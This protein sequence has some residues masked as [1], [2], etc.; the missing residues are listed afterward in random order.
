MA[1]AKIDPFDVEALEKSLNDSATRVSA[2]WISF[3]IFALYL[4]TAATTVTHR[5][6]LLDEPVKLPVL[7]IDLPLWGFF[8]LAPI[9]FL[10]FHIYVLLQVLLL[11]RTAVVYN[12]AVNEKVKA[13]AD[14]SRIRQRLANT[15]F[16][17]IFAGSPR[18][19]EGWLGWLL[20]AMAWI[21]LVV[22]P[23]SIL[24]AFQFAFLPYHS[25]F[26]TWTHRLLLLIELAIS[27]LLWPLVL[28]AGDNLNWPRMKRRLKRSMTF[29]APLLLSLLCRQTSNFP[30]PKRRTC[31]VFWRRAR[32]AFPIT[33]FL[34][35][36][37]F[38]L[39]LATY[40]GEWHV[41]LITGQSWSAV[42]CDRWFTNSFD[43]LH[44]PGIDIVDDKKLS[45][46]VEATSK[47][48]LPG[49]AGERTR[50]LRGRNLNC[51]DLS[52]A[53]LRRADFSAAHLSGADLTRSALEG[54]SFVR[55]ELR[56]AILF[57]AKLQGASLAEAQ[58]QGASL[59]S[60]ELAGAT[61]DR[62]SLQGATLTSAQLQG[63]LLAYASLQGANLIS[64]DLQG[65]SLFQARLQGASLE[66]AI[67][68]GATLDGARLQG[69][70]LNSA[71][72]QGASLAGAWLQGADLSNAKFLW[73]DMS[74]AYIWRAV[75]TACTGQP[76]GG[77]PETIL[78]AERDRTISTARNE[79]LSYIEDITSD[80][81]TRPARDLIHFHA[82]NREYA[83]NHLKRRLITDDVAAIALGRSE[84]NAVAKSEAEF[85]TG[86][87]LFLRN[88]VC[89]APAN[90]RALINSI[91]RDRLFKFGPA[92][93][94]SS[95]PFVARVF[96]GR[97]DGKPCA[98]TADLSDALKGSLRQIVDNAPPTV[99]SAAPPDDG[100]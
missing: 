16:A 17:Q 76:V 6:F 78:D 60:A 50:N 87:A 31:P 46:I 77:K 67:L 36:I 57:E 69:A 91:A 79:V 11:G 45:E 63:T 18:E 90:R 51:A 44:L 34:L 22:A 15:L 80:I 19:R 7:N 48:H 29:S 73:T 13:T 42:R 96:L 66:G 95:T 27:F 23:I 41:N 49:D 100:D 33:V 54:A 43:R 70:T 68:Q 35:F 12:E 21:T 64:A 25:W 65:A 5:Q 93:P 74:D 84:C 9:L 28:N 37:L 89:A 81:P 38:S 39:S 20:K 75:A 4:L 92:D 32:S 26:V 55:S 1:E 8:F 52:S 88:L 82:G 40:P 62:A 24:L 47:R 58:L 59:L 94:R 10:I 97:E 14:N 86:L 2:L 98:A 53:D 85:N 99:P 61:L 3:L 71:S 30:W 83:R 56:G 72:L